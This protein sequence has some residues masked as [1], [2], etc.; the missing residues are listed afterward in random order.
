M[1]PREQHVF[2]A[3]LRAAET[4]DGAGGK[5]AGRELKGKGDHATLHSPV[6]CSRESLHARG[7][8]SS[9]HPL[10]TRLVPCSLPSPTP[11]ESSERSPAP[12]CEGPQA[13][14]LC[15]R[16]LSHA[17]PAFRST[18][19]AA[20]TPLSV[21]GSPAFGTRTG[22]PGRWTP[23]SSDGKGSEGQTVKRQCAC[24]VDGTHHRRRVSDVTR[25][26]RRG[27]PSP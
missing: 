20:H 17:Q 5:S 7:S 8:S 19:G 21:R 6:S 25:R 2:P 22:P 11:S 10:R 18:P 14:V 15:P 13:A 12:R 23:G 27:R 1:P 16:L 4:P 26:R 9:G 3:M 24:E